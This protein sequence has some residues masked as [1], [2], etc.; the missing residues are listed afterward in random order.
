MISDDLHTCNISVCKRECN[1]VAHSLAALGCK[2]PSGC[3]NTWE[4]VPLDLE[5]LVTS[6]SAGKNK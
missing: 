2:L 6:D 5:D 1:R 4:G 3:Y